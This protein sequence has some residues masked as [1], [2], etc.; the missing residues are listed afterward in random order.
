MSHINSYSRAKLNDRSPFEVF[1][2][3]YGE[4]ILEKLG[5]RRIPSNE[6]ILKPQL[7]KK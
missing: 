2:F 6:I 1:S 4:G 3:L 7:L 5:L